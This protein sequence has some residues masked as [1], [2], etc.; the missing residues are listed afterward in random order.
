LGFAP[1]GEKAPTPDLRFHLPQATVA[2]P[3]AWPF[4]P[5]ADNQPQTAAPSIVPDIDLDS[6]P[7][8]DRLGDGY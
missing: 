8:R 7:G 5:V 6:L 4:N 2:A 1:D 3:L